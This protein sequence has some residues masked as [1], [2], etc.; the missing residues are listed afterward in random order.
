MQQMMRVR[1]GELAALTASMRQARRG[2][3]D[4]LDELE[5]RLLVLGRSWDG[6][7]ERAFALARREWADAL[8]RMNTALAEAALT[9]SRAEEHYRSTQ[10]AVTRL[11]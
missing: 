9:A 7:A 4:E 1:P 2:I 5:R 3:Q 6:Q 10:Q 11:W 8:A